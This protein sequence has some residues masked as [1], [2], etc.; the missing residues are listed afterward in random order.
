MLSKVCC[1][2]CCCVPSFRKQSSVIYNGIC[3]SAA[4]QVGELVAPEL[5]PFNVWGDALSDLP[6]VDNYSEVRVVGSS[7]CSRSM[8]MD[9]W[10]V[11]S[12]AG[13]FWQHCIGMVVGV[14]CLVIPALLP[15]IECRAASTNSGLLLKVALRLTLC[16]A[17]IVAAGLTVQAMCATQPL[18]PVRVLGPLPVS[19]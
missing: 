2:V 13:F 16:A 7:Q 11:V 1:P 18:Y 14:T 4:V 3:C 9:K 12:V 10:M 17:W 15:L 19:D 5:M 6:V 8:W